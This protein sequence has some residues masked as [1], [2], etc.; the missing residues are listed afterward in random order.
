MKNTKNYYIGLDIGTDSVGYALTD[1]EYKLLKFKGEPAWGVTVFDEAQ[2]GTERRGFRTSRRRLERRKQRV[3]LIQ[4]LFAEEITKVDGRFF[5]RLQESAL[6]PEDKSEKYSIFSDGDYTDINYHTD[7][8][9]IHHLIYELITSRKPHDVRLVYLACSYLVSHRGH[10]LSN[11]G[12]NELELFT[13]FQT[14]HINRNKPQKG[15][16][17]TLV[18][19]EKQFSKMEFIVGEY[20]SDV[21]DSE[22]R[23]VIL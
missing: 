18:V 20:H 7:Y 22:D 4:E 19:T 2:P 16:V 15:I 21:I 17:Q 14:V 6:Y 5:I 1:E 3:G 11:I 13:D 10:F 23:L 8:P 9:T 12:V